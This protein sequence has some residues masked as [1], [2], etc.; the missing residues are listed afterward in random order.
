MSAVTAV[1]SQNKWQMAILSSAG[2]CLYLCESVDDIYAVTFCS[3]FLTSWKDVAINDGIQCSDCQV[4]PLRILIKP[5]DIGI[6]QKHLH[7]SGIEA[8]VCY[9]CQCNPYSEDVEE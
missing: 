9:L 3:P 4:Y 7:T 2:N 5:E 1:T 6:S 8:N